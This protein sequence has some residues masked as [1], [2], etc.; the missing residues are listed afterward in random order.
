MHI[1]VSLFRSLNYPTISFS[2]TW[3]MFCHIPNSIYPAAKKSLLFKD[4]SL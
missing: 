2:K 4:Y 3:A 1:N